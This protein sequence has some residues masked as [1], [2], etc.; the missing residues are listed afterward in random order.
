MLQGPNKL[1][2]YRLRWL[3][4]PLRLAKFESLWIQV[5]SI[6]AVFGILGD[7]SLLSLSFWQSFL[8]DSVVIYYCWMPFSILAVFP[9]YSVILGFWGSTNSS[10]LLPWVPE[11]VLW[12]SLRGLVLSL[13]LIIFS[14]WCCLFESPL[15]TFHSEVSLGSWP[16]LLGFL[17]FQTQ[18]LVVLLLIIFLRW[19]ESIPTRL[20]VFPTTFPYSSSFWIPWDATLLAH[21]WLLQAL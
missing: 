15:L 1:K 19:A 18:L 6:V 21:E 3:S 10:L 11:P 13:F 5:C 12:Q 9:F 8:S 7:I 14:F 20:K 2:N 16:Q 17:P 4:K